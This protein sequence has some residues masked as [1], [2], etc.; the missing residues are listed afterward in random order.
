MELRQTQQ[1]FKDLLYHMAQVE[2][3]DKTIQLQLSP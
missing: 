1:N 3:N 2:K